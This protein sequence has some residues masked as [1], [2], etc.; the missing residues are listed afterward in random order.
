MKTILKILAA[1]VALLIIAGAIF[2]FANNETLPK[3]KNPDKADELANKILK[4][5]N[6]DAYQNT[7]LIEWNFR[8][9]H[10]YKWYKSENKV[11]VSWDKNKV[12]LHTNQPE[13]NEVI[14]SKENGG[15]EELIEKAIKIF[16]NDSFWLVAPYKVNDKGTKRS[17]VKVDEKEALLVTYTSGGSTPGDSYLWILDSTF[18]P[19][20]FKMWVGIIPI[21]GVEATWGNWQKTEAG[22]LLPKKHI[23]SPFGLEIEMG[24]PTATN[25]KADEL[26]NKIL[27]AIKHENYKKTNIIEWSFAGKRSFKWNKK[28]H[29]VDVSWDTIRV[30]LQ[31]NNLAKSVVFY[32]EIKQETVD[33]EMLQKALD[34][35]N[36]DSFWLVSPHKLFEKGIV[37]NII[38]V[39][40]K[41]VLKV[42]YTIGGTTP[43][44]SYVW[45]LDSTYVPKKWF[46]NVETKNIVNVPATWEDWITTESGT[47]LPKNHVFEGGRGLSMG[48]VKGTK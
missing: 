33:K 36:N 29:I 45:I 3:G 7:E 1:I 38:K 18:I 8:N 43:G 46:M 34:I 16:N 37:R 22:I 12:I 5:L 41:D 4:A 20:K 24:N 15:K 11:E 14:A 30:N 25:P 27:F 13:K 40:E 6:Y 28:D 17:I 32:N 39:D 19:V 35:F 26:A 9:E 21:G 47:L 44:D 2:Y 10:F 31:P 48:D 42:N 23:M